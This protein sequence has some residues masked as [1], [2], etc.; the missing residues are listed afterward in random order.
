MIIVTN[1]MRKIGPN[2]TSMD[3]CRAI[4]IMATT[5]AEAQ[6]TL[7]RLMTW[8]SPT[9]PVGAF[10]YSHGLE[11]AIHDGIISDRGT[12]VAWLR[13]LI[14]RGSVWNDA[15]CLAEAWRRAGSDDDCFAVAELAEALAGSRERYM[16]TTLQGRAFMDA[17]QAWASK[18]KS[19]EEQQGYGRAQEVQYPYPV[20]VGLTAAHHGIA[21]DAALTAYLHGFTSNLVQAAMRLVPLGQN[22]GLAALAALEEV[23]LATSERASKSTLDSLGSC[24]VLS[25]IQSMKHETQYSRVFRS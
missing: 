8:L 6:E 1:A 14:E 13:D 17:A 4:H 5:M 16:E 22:D 3:D 20:A 11:R 21:L 9:F 7:L 10:A 18:R 19:S 12:L 2:A 15:V 24:T 23:I 25:D